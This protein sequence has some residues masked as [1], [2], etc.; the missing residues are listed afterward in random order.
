MRIGLRHSADKRFFPLVGEQSVVGSSHGCNIVLDD[1]GVDPE[2]ARI[3][4]TN[5]GIEIDDLGTSG[6]TIVN[7]Y[8]IG[9]HFLSRDD[10]LKFGTA[11]LRLELDREVTRDRPSCQRC[12]AEFET[13]AQR[14]P[15]GLCVACGRRGSSTFPAIT[16]SSFHPA[17]AE[18]AI[19]AGLTTKRI[20][21]DE[22]KTPVVNAAVG[23]ANWLPGYELLC[24]LG[25]GS[26]GRV[27]KLRQRDTGRTVAGKH[28]YLQGTKAQGR[29]ER[30]IEALQRLHH[31]GIVALVEVIR[32]PAP[33]LIM[34]FVEGPSLA[35]I[36]RKDR[37]IDPGRA[38]RMA[39]RIA[40]GLAYAT[41][42]GVFHRDVKPSNM[43]I[44]PGD[45]AKLTDFGLVR[46]EDTR[47]R[48]TSEGQ[49]IGTPH[50]MA[51]EQVEGGDTDGRTDVWGLGA[52]FF[53]A[54]T[55]SLPFEAATPV[56]LFKKIGNAPIDFEPVR[57]IAGEGP[58]EVFRKCLERD[59]RDRATPE[60]AATW[61]GHLAKN[62]GYSP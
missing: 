4:I 23:G 60:E 50:Y 37:R 40:S 51:P 46:F 18:P 54:I 61:F 24:V 14:G 31:R 32:V 45:D 25:E 59:I 20:A 5:L 3:R 7:G 19:R 27:Y 1:P 47:T 48:L 28:L 42:S 2:H 56:E 57:E 58:A 62:Q 41:A 6:G 29:F 52:S 36:V 15:R 13:E 49:W 26:Q 44:G 16:S 35:T 22:P 17:S 9:R 30:E 10:E 53:Q 12:G 55:G 34:E 8:R 38:L 39:A 43:L 33:V 21:R 11:V